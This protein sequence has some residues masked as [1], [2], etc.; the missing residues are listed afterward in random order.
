[1][2]VFLAPDCVAKLAPSAARNQ[3]CASPPPRLP[4]LRGTVRDT[5]S[6]T[7]P[8]ASHTRKPKLRQIIPLQRFSISAFV[9]AAILD[10]LEYPL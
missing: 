5:V 10:V 4:A 2:L 1:M 8:D 6:R 7:N 3:F 9:C